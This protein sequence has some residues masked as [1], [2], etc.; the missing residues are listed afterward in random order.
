MVGVQRVR[1]RGRSD[2]SQTRRNRI[3]NQNKPAHVSQQYI[4]ERSIPEPNSGCWIWLLSLGRDGYAQGKYETAHRI[5]F[6]GFKGSI[7]EGL[8]VDHICKTR[9]CVNPEHLRAVTHL[10][11][12]ST[13]DA[14]T[15]HRNRRKTHCINGHELSGYNLILEN[16]RGIVMRKC[17]ACK[18]KRSNVCGKKRYDRLKHDPAFMEAR[19]ARRRKHPK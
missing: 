8:E 12:M 19:N 14:I 11:N 4:L 16:W 15:N 3:W 13:A 1:P 9:W 18:N 17:R 10:E 5:S 7:P 2:A 6:R